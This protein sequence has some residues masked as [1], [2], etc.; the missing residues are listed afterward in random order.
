MF[1]TDNCPKQQTF[2][3][4]L[5]VGRAIPQDHELML[6]RKAVDW[7][8]LE[9]ELAR[10]YDSA[11]GRPACPVLLLRILILQQYADLS[12]REVHE[13]LG[14]NLLYRAFVGLGMDDAVPDDTNLVRFRARIGL[15]GLQR[16][17]EF[18][19]K[20]WEA[21]GLISGNRRAADGCHMWA[22]VARRSWVSLLRTGRRLVIEAVTVHDQL[23]GAALGATYLPESSTTPEPRGPEALAA[24]KATTTKLLDEV[25]DFDQPA[26]RERAAVLRAMLADKD[27][28]VSFDDIDARWG[29]KAPDK[30]FCGYKT[31]ESIDPDSRIIT[32]V[33]VVPGN[34]NEAVQTDVLLA[35][36]TTAVEPGATFLG[37]GL[38]NNATTVEQ[39]EQAGYTPCL[40]GLRAKRLSDSYDYDAE[41][42]QMVCPCQ[43]RSIGKC[44]V[45][46]GDLYYFSTTD[47][48][49]CQRKAECLTKGERE[50]KAMP[51]RRVFLSDVRKRKVVAGEAGAAN[52]RKTL[53]LR[54]RIE[55]KFDEQMNRHGL[56]RARYWGKIK[57]FGQV[58]LNVITVNLKRAVKLIARGFRASTALPEAAGA[59]A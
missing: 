59:L 30:P 9:A 10:Y 25:A 26:V 38:Y 36:E 5:R 16:M 12:D 58:L 2:G 14:Y 43:K 20:Q 37:D 53:K 39:V 50:G 11:Q 15:E 29:H 31:H 57:T 19:N 7:T 28:P 52:T 4:I 21:A 56:R 22:K 34:A 51:R 55:P 27:Q 18:M 40:A 35:A 1:K 24:E 41:H 3:D 45:G 54:S 32:A 17:F 48:S 46:N 33:D 6:M 13:Q 23:R 44:R 49:C 47:C 42:D 8:G